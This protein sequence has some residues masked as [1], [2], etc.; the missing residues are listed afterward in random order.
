MNISYPKRHSEFEIQ[1]L[2][3]SALQLLGY[4]VR[5]EVKSSPCRFDLVI[6]RN[7]E[8]ICIIE[9]KKWIKKKTPSKTKQYDRYMSYGLPL[10][11]CGHIEDIQETVRKVQELIS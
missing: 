10:V 2:L 4:D 11:Y 9:V 5:G 1:A 7:K 8:A 6:F 3:F